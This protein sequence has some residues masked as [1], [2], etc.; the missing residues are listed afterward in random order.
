MLIKT[1]G[2]TKSSKQTCDV[3]AVGILLKDGG[4]L[5]L[6]L[7]AV[8]LICEPLCGQPVSCIS[9]NY[10]YISRLELAD[11]CYG[12]DV[13]NVDTLIGSDQYWDLVTCNV[14]HKANGPIAV[15]IRLGWVLLGPVE[16]FPCQGTVANL[17][18]VQPTHWL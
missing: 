5:E 7:L 12:E 11:H 14:I 13:L 15:H 17:V 6:S 3:V 4:M 1:F 18:T 2:S 16:G 10:E 9:Q 8:P